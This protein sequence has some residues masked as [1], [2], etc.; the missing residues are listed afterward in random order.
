M[1]TIDPDEFAARAGHVGATT[2]ELDAAGAD[3]AVDACPARGAPVSITGKY[4]TG[5]TYTIEAAGC[6]A[7]GAWL[8][9]GYGCDRPLCRVC[10]FNGTSTDPRDNAWLRYVVYWQSAARVLLMPADKFAT[11]EHVRKSIETLKALA[12]DADA[13][14]LINTLVDRGRLSQD[15]G[16]RLA[17]KHGLLD[18]LAEAVR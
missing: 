15:D 9:G 4:D 6:S 7:V 12:T 16:I 17:K 3:A 8:V 2:P 14:A 5:Q 10:R 18:A 13:A 11:E 1:T